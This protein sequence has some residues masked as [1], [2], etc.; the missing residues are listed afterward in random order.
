VIPKSQDQV[1]QI[2]ERLNRSFMFS[3]L[4]DKERSIVIGAMEERKVSAGDS[5]ITQGEDGDEL[6][7]V[8]SGE[9][10]CFKKFP[11]NEEETY[12][13][14]YLSGD[15]FGELALL[16]NAPRAATIRAKTDALLWALDRAT[17]KN[18]VKDAA[19]KKREIYDDFLSKV[20]LLENIDAYERSQIADA[21][22]TA[23][24]NNGDYVIREGDWGEV[25]Y[26]VVEG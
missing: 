5:V 12:L 25:F 23:N 16:Y 22:K 10:A 2:T 11:G 3:N 4:D 19:R 17:F 6:F 21:F 7:V 20:D 14:D 9:L 15:A 26:F 1:S 13:K 18:I 24:F 8:D